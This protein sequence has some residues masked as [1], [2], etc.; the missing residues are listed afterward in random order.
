MTHRPM[1]GSPAI[2]TGVNA[3][4][5]ETNG[6]PR[7]TD[8]RGRERSP[9]GS[10]LGAVEGP[11]V[12]IGVTSIH[13]GT[14]PYGQTDATVAIELEANGI[15]SDVAIAPASPFDHF[16]NRLDLS[17]DGQ[18]RVEDSSFFMPT[19]TL[20]AS[21]FLNDPRVTIFARIDAVQPVRSLTGEFRFQYE[22]GTTVSLPC[23]GQVT[24]ALLV[25]VA[26]PKIRTCGDANPAFMGSVTGLVLNDS[27]SSVATGSPLFSSAPTN[28]TGRGQYPIVGSGLTILNSNDELAQAPPTP[29]H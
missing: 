16:R 15:S 6:A 24:P 19:F 13:L 29:R 23:T 5:L 11:S 20:P 14:K 3:G 10:T 27:L 26:D 8:Q 7:G 9:Y 2:G 21:R 18:V 12:R 1:P 25:Y 22:A 17:S 4:A 28:A